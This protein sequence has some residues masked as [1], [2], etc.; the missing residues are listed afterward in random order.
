MVRSSD[1]IEADYQEA[2]L[3]READRYVRRGGRDTS[4]PAYTDVELARKSHRREESISD[5]CTELARGEAELLKRCRQA[6]GR[7]AATP[8]QR[9]CIVLR[10]QRV[11]YPLIAEAI[12]C[13][14][15]TVY[16]ELERGY[17]AVRE[18]MDHKLNGWWPNENEMRWLLIA[19]FKWKH[20]RLYT[21]E[22]EEAMIE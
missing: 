20:Y 17:R 10:A 12:G 5:Q 14:E 4:Y 11:T 3:E 1:D 21:E 2:R 13:S 18:A 9:Q 22:W 19:V 6:I 7:S 15:R 8:R 16:H